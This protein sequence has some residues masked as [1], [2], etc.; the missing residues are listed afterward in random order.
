MKEATTSESELKD[1]L[2]AKLNSLKD[3]MLQITENML[4]AVQAIGP[5][6][7]WTEVVKKTKQINR[8]RNQGPKV[9]INQNCSASGNEQE[10]TRE[11]STPT[12]R[13]YANVLK[14][15]TRSN[16]PAP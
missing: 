6:D 16:K 3:Q 15:G 1:I 13:T 7:N 10:G 9:M 4:A 5:S 11:H 12:K 8:C 14:G 2:Q